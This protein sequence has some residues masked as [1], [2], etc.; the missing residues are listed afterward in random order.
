MKNGFALIVVAPLCLLAQ[1]KGN[2]VQVSGSCN[3]VATGSNNQITITCPGLSKE[4]AEDMVRLMNS[5][6]SRQLDPKKVYSQLDQISG[7]VA[8]LNDTVSAAVNPLADAP[9]EVTDRIR[10]FNQLR[11]DCNTYANQWSLALMKAPQTS[12]Q[13]ATAPVSPRSAEKDTQYSAEYATGLGPR[14]IAW[15]SKLTSQT[16][17]LRSAQDWSVTKTPDQ[18][19]FICK[20]VAQLQRQYSA[21]SAADYALVKE[22]QELQQACQSLLV[23]WMFGENFV[24]STSGS[25]AQSAINVFTAGIEALNREQA[26]QYKQ[27]LAPQLI[28][29]RDQMLKVIPMESKKD[30]SAVSDNTQIGAVCGDFSGLVVNYQMKVGQDLLKVKVQSRNKK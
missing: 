8:N 7:T 29:A 17:S 22:S 26:A 5:I 19:Q 28:A 18:L 23:K 20:G 3:T 21:S 4:R 24:S 10:R 1:T 13:P 15:R 2:S 9:P 16:R 6:L 14:L 11:T 30:Y 25:S 12:T 27:T